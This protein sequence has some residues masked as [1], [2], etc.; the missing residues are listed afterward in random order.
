VLLLCERQPGVSKDIN[1]IMHGK[2]GAPA[3]STTS[4]LLHSKSLIEEV[5]AGKVPAMFP[6]SNPLH[7][8]LVAASYFP[9]MGGLETHV[10]ETGKRLADAGVYVTILTTDKSGRLPI[11]EESNNVHIHRVR[12]WP[13]NKDYYFAPGIYRFITRGRWDLVHCQGYHTLVAPLTLLASLRA[14]IPYVLTFHSGGHSS[15]LRKAL[16]GLQWM[17]LRPLLKR[18]QKL[19]SVSEFEADFFREQLRLPA[20]TFVVIP[21]GAHLPQV[22]EL[23]ET[24]IDELDSDSLIISIGRLERYKGHQRL[25]AALPK[26]RE[27]VSNARLLILGAGPYESALWK[28]ARKHGVADRIEIRAVPGSDRHAMAEI[29]SRAVLVTLLSEYESQGIAV[30]EALALRR[31][32]LVADTSGLRELADR[33]LARKVALKSTPEKIAAEIVRQIEEPLIPTPV[34]LPTWDDCAANL[35]ALYQSVIPRPLCVS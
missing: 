1:G 21:N 25:I 4:N 14:N 13:R 20:E 28:L 17:L 6:T 19:I 8:L 31:P 18:A 23:T 11:V 9:Y 16:R 30:M 15:S 22:S 12:S 5:N 34:E 29:L 35:L 24:A 32:V 27:Q 7:V 2:N 33:G 3:M 26:V 10:Y